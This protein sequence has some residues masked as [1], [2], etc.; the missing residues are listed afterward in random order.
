MLDVKSIAGS[1]IRDVKKGIKDSDFLSAL[2]LV[3]SKL[4]NQKKFKQESNKT[5]L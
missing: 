5:G 2:L 1:D 3:E 4:K